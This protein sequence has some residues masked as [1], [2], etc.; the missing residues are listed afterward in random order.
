MK[1][2]YPEAA[3]AIQNW[4]T[5]QKLPPGSNLP[6]G[7][8]LAKKLG[9]SRSTFGRA[10][11]DLITQGLLFRTGYKLK[12]GR[13]TSR[14]IEGTIYLVSHSDA[15]L[16]VTE[17]IFREREVKFKKIKLLSLIKGNLIH[18]LRKL[19]EEKPDGLL[20]W[21]PNWI[22]G[23]E[24]VL[25]STPI[26]IVVCADGMPLHLKVDSC[27]MDLY[28]GTEIAL[29][30]LVELGHRQIAHITHQKPLAHEKVITDSYR[31]ICRDLD[32]KHSANQIWTVK[33][34]NH[35][36]SYRNTLLDQLKQHPEVTAVLA[37]CCVPF[38]GTIAQTTH[39]IAMVGIYE[40][41]T[42]S[43]LT[44]VALPDGGISVLQSACNQMIL[45]IQKQEA[46]LPR[47][48]SNHAF[49]LPALTIRAS[50]RKRSA[51]NH[52]LKTQ[53]TT[54]TSQLSPWESWRQTYP[55]LKQSGNYWR[56]LD[57]SKLANHKLSHTNGWLGD[58]P[59]LHF[60]P[61]LHSVHGVPFDVIDPVHNQG[62]NVITF[63][64]PH[65]HSTYGEKLPSTVKIP[66]KKC[67]KALYFLHGCGWAKYQEPFAEY[68][69]HFQDGKSLSIPLIP[70]GEQ[71][72]SKQKL[73]KANLQD[74]WPTQEPM[75][76]P[77]A[78]HATV[79]N[80]VN[81]QEYERY[82]YTLEWIN[83]RPKEVLSCI[84]VRVDPKAGPALGL[85]AVT[86][87]F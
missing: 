75:N 59:L 16:A 26:P 27:G 40:L 67:T 17:K 1:S 55:P 43:H 12:V 34:F 69:L 15:I 38:F 23:L 81:P 46:G 58:L 33:T 2:Q 9:F 3:K 80:P 44:S 48:F 78:L 42:H 63:Q 79:F 51:Q 57:L 28:R 74:W 56:Q 82:L 29:Q 37:T 11:Q 13:E 53:V 30:H 5:Q 62:Q 32:L 45:L 49:F 41:H 77:Q 66:I 21:L 22:E 31:K 85:I 64:S 83:P 7:R 47:P 76:F 6:S 18:N 8:S 35:E 65:S 70:V 36:E 19:I 14:P 50:S 86:A 20:L 87:L 54:P 52:S 73:F 84:E 4:I 60:P 72:K 25:E 71:R 10:C 68:L 61:G 39:D 24:D